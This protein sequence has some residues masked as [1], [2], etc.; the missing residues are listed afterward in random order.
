MNHGN[1]H[2]DVLNIVPGDIVVYDPADVPGL[3]PST[4]SPHIVTCCT[5]PGDVQLLLTC[6]RIVLQSP[7]VM[8]RSADWSRQ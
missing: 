7:Y 8:G 2:E 6:G 3:N 1:F 4:A 5:S